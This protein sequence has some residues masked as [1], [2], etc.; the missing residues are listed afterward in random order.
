MAQAANRSS[1]GRVRTAS[2]TMGEVHVGGELYEGSEPL[3]RGLAVHDA[4][5]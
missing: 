5:D 2:P 4:W 3:F 1:R